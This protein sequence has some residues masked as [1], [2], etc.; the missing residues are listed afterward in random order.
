MSEIFPTIGLSAS[1]HSPQPLARKHVRVL[2]ALNA[3]AGVALTFPRNGC[4]PMNYGLLFRGIYA[5]ISLALSRTSCKQKRTQ[6]YTSVGHNINIDVPF[7][8]SSCCRA[9]Y[10]NNSSLMIASLLSQWLSGI[11]N[12]S[13]SRTSVPSEDARRRQQLAAAVFIQSRKVQS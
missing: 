9:D 1:I 4:P 11:R 10:P 5:G 3:V 8:Y 6:P 13:P 7:R 2:Y 12:E